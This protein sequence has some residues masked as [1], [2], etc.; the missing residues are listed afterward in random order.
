VASLGIWGVL[1][2][3]RLLV[4]WLESFLG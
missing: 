2:W 3:E 1:G 4:L